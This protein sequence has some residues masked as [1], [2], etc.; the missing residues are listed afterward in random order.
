MKRVS[1]I[2]AVVVLCIGVPTLMLGQDNPNIGTW[3]L[4]A[5]KSK[6]TGMKGPT[7]LTRTVAADGD[8]VKY[9]FEGT[10]ADGSALKYGFTVKYDGKDNA[11]T[12]SGMPYGAD[13]IAIKRLGSN[14]FSATLKKDD[15]IIGT[16]T[17]V[18]S[19]NG[20]TITLTGKGTVDGKG[21]SSTQVY[22]KQ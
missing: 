4:N 10:G 17:S 20:K 21:V 7:S 13:H 12:G 9:S 16:S 19:A 3:K 1:L 6:Y 11:I 5:E 8:S 14:K 18:V 15:K 22:D 2:L